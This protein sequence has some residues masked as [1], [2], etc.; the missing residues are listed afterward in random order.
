M[1]IGIDITS[2]QTGHKFRG[3]GEYAYNLVKNL[4]VIDKENRYFLFGLKNVTCD[5]EMRQLN[6]ELVNIVYPRFG[7]LSSIVSHQLFL[8]LVLR[9]MKL[10]LFHFLGITADPSTPNLPFIHICRTIVTVHDMNLRRFSRIY[11]KKIRKRLFYKA[12]LFAVKR[13]EH[14]ITDSNSS[15]SDMINFLR[16]DPCKVSVISLAPSLVYR[17]KTEFNLAHVKRLGINEGIILNVGTMDFTKNISRLIDAYHLLIQ[18]ANFEYQLVIVG[19]KNPQ[20]FPALAKKVKKLGLINKVIF[21]DYLPK[22]DLKVLY[23]V[24]KVFV[25]PS[26]CEGFGLPPLEAMSFGVPVITSNVSSLPEIV[27][28]AAFLVNPYNTQEIA[29]AMY[30]VLTDK[31]LRDKLV[32]LGRERIKHF[33]WEKTAR[34]TLKVYE[35]VAGLV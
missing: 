7:R 34:E 8:P 15:K 9:S 6:F 19:K 4:S 28:G 17:T 25:F 5:L 20:T 3:I 30:R 18:Q 11:L 10:D 24:A 12:I 31:T 22:K 13:A 23:S 29:Q 32:M 27:N 35:K 14:I 26:L 21:T 2:L 33:S 1:R 16:I